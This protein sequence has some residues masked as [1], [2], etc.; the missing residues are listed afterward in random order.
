M[1]VRRSAIRHRRRHRAVQV[2]LAE[3]IATF[4][5]P[6]DRPSSAPSFGSGVI[7]PGT[8]R[9][10]RNSAHLP[11]GVARFRGLGALPADT[12]MSA[13]PKSRLTS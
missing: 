7:A 6:L 13:R 1:G 11:S 12:A 2:G 10:Q 9:Y 3:R 4:T 8:S 5:T